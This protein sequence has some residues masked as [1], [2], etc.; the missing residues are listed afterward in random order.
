VPKSISLGIALYIAALVDTLWGGGIFVLV[1][2]T[3]FLLYQGFLLY[4]IYKRQNWARIA[5]I[6]IV[7]FIF[8][9]SL[10]AYRYI[11]SI[12][13]T[14]LLKPSFSDMLEPILRIAAVACFFSKSSTRWLLSASLESPK[15]GESNGRP[16]EPRRV[17]ERNFGLGSTQSIGIG[18][19]VA[20]VAI[21]AFFMV[22]HDLR[23]S[24]PTDA[25]TQELKAGD[26]NYPVS[27]GN[28]THIIPLVAPRMD[29]SNYRFNADYSSDVKL[30]GHRVGVAETVAY[31]LTIPIE[32]VQSQDSKY[33][34]SIIIDKFLSGKCGWQFR[35]VGFTRPDGIGN[36]F[37]LLGD[38]RSNPSP[39]TAPHIDMWCYRVTEGQFE[40]VDSKCE[41][42]ASLRWPDAKRRVSPEF[43]AKFSPE[44]QDANGI[45]Y[46]TTETKE[47][48]VEFHDLN[49]IPS[50]LV[51]VGDR[52][53]QI[54]ALQEARAAVEASP[55]GQARLCFEQAN[56]AYGRTH[57]PP[58]TATVHTQRDAVFAL[59]N[60]CRAD[61]GLPPIYPE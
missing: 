14:P 21:G 6:I 11:Y 8:S 26:A 2:G 48:T 7:L 57:P 58:D 20:G 59:R 5:L 46:I 56:I 47:L 4:E 39:A 1:L 60:K 43:L 31:G 54:K 33:R 23:R 35:G 10:P 49:A 45:V 53:E 19:L 40:S 42:L 29:L 30:C 37:G 34:G 32:M 50:A 9:R 41:I 3:P 12:G 24:M 17:D 38:R 55:A 36:A 28:P 61:F 16:A 18:I 27:N 13:V 52:A 51:P 44:Q 15:D 22:I 25:D